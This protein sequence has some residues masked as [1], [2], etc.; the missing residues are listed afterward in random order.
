MKRDN[1]GRFLAGQ[2]GNPQGRK[3]EAEKVR[4][5]LEPRRDEL[6][7]QAVTLALQGDATALR[8]CLDRLAPPPKAE[9]Q[10]VEVPG[11]AEAETLTAK[12][13][14]LMAAVGKGQVSPDVG[15]RLLAALGNYAKALELDEL[16][17]RIAALEGGGDDGEER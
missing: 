6:V 7:S 11:L 5:L 15:E 3:P 16:E 12:A 13:E 10:P 8:L 4:E 14:T 9:A 1:K 2:S 17:R